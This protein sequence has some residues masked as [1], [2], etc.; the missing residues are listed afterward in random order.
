MTDE[1]S[2]ED[3]RSSFEG[4]P[5]PPGDTPRPPP[6][7]APTPNLTCLPG[8]HGGEPIPR[9]AWGRSARSDSSDSAGDPGRP[10]T[11]WPRASCHSCPHDTAARR[12]N[13]KEEEEEK[14]EN[15]IVVIDCC[16]LSRR[17]RVTTGHSQH[18]TDNRPSSE[19][20]SSHLGRSP[21]LPPRN[22]NGSEREK[23]KAV[24]QSWWFIKQQQPQD[25]SGIAGYL[26]T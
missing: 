10:L 22:L 2:G 6:P 12:R 14:G 1:H 18:S 24:K 19:T 3:T 7:Q 16:V 20:Q 9:N 21:P 11:G 4:Y 25:S 8:P 13:I 5:A 17:N 26:T 23:K 15:I